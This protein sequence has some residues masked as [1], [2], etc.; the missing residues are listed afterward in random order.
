MVLEWA[1]EVM[2]LPMSADLAQEQMERIVGALRG[3]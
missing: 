3:I 2:S 1:D